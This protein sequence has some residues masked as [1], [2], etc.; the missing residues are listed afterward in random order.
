LAAFHRLPFRFTR[1][2]L[3]TFYPEEEGRTRHSFVSL[4]FFFSR[5]FISV[6]PPFLCA[7]VSPPKIDWLPRSPFHDYLRGHLVPCDFFSAPPSVLVASRPNAKYTPCG[8]S[9]D[10][11]P[12]LPL[13]FSA[14]TLSY[15]TAPK[16]NLLYTIGLF[17]DFAAFFSRRDG[18]PPY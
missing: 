15:A 17:L 14:F 18:F 8:E 7:R 6:T 12:F 1:N 3:E 2:L 4:F 13:F 9:F 5:L 10:N 11:F 16:T